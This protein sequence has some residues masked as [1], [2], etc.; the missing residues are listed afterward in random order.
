MEHDVEFAV[1]SDWYAVLGVRVLQVPSQKIGEQNY[2]TE[3]VSA[4]FDKSD[5]LYFEERSLER[6]LGKISTERNRARLRAPM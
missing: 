1:E 4:G 2:I 3:T 6:V 5:R